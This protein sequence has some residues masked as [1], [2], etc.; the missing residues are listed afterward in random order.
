MWRKFKNEAVTNRSKIPK[1]KVNPQK[2]PRKIQLLVMNPDEMRITG[3]ALES[4]P[5]ERKQTA[6][7]KR[8]AAPQTNNPSEITQILDIIQSPHLVQYLQT[9]KLLAT[10]VRCRCRKPM[11]LRI[12]RQHTDGFA[13]RLAIPVL[14]SALS[15]PNWQ[16]A[17][18]LCFIYPPAAENGGVIS[19]LPYDQSADDLDMPPLVRVEL[20]LANLNEN[21]QS[22]DSEE[23]ASFP[24]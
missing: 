20:C 11:T 4:E 13:F 12:L 10:E 3:R 7:R 18:R 9:K 21:S 15:C 2:Q 17:E 23:N 19:V 8:K 5:E 24:N 14:A 1:A 22:T 16:I 6:K